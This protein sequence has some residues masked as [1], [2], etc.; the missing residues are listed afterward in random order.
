MAIGVYFA[1]T[2]MNSATYDRALERLDAAGAGSPAGR[3]FHA[4]FGDANDLQV[5]DVWSSQADF[6]AFGEMLMPI[7]SELGAN[8]EQP[9]IVEV[10]NVLG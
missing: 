8:L 1:S 4:S 9:E 6:D 3:V 5:F 10:H 7:L 2:G